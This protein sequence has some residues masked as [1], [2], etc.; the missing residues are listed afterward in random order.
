MEK[1]ERLNEEETYWWIP[2][3]F[4][5]QTLRAILKCL[6]LLHHDSPSKNTEST[7]VTSNQPLLEEE[8][9]EDVAMEESVI[10]TS[11]G[12]KNVLMTSRGTKMKAKKTKKEQKSSG[13]SG[14]HHDFDL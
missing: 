11:R 2:F 12:S 6:G 14:G 5:D 9:E 8:E 1:Y 3:K 7:P 10:V 13:R 4:L